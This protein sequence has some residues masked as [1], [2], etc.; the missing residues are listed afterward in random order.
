[1]VTIRITKGIRKA[2]YKILGLKIRPAPLVFIASL[3][4]LLS[5]FN[6]GTND[7]EINIPSVMARGVRICERQRVIWTLETDILKATPKKSAP[8]RFS[9]AMAES[10]SPLPE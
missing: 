5:P 9:M 3:T 8:K 1:M 6:I 10:R 2:R 4:R 7:I